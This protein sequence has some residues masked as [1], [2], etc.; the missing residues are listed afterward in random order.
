MQTVH[1]ILQSKGSSVV[2]VGPNDTVLHALGVMA[3]HGVG[4]VLVLDDGKLVGI[5][6]QTQIV[7]PK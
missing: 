1:D 3:E 6:T 2:S 5:V 7:M 4:A